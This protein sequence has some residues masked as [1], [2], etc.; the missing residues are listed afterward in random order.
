[1]LLVFFISEIHAKSAVKSSDVT[2]NVINIL[3]Q[4]Y[5]AKMSDIEIIDLDESADTASNHA[6]HDE[7]PTGHDE[8][9]TGHD[10]S[11]TEESKPESS[12]GHIEANL[13]AIS[14]EDSATEPQ[15]KGWN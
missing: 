4:K 11:T 13:V 6:R 14:Q 8:S 12:S 5:S 10:E 9:T 7:S 3:F 15:G 2:Y 1:M